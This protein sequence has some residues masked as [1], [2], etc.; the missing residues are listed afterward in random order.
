[1]KQLETR[2]M[3]LPVVGN[4][5]GPKAIRAVGAWLKAH[6]AFVSA[7]YL[8]NVEQY[9]NMDGIWG[10]FCSNAAQLPIDDT[11]QFIR[12]YRGG[13]G[14]GFGGG[15]LNQGIFPMSTDLARCATQ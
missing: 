6:N 9:L 13:G 12:S 3:L 8:S 7:F 15:S 1:M 11:S 10:D 14:P 5:A 4:F 2:N